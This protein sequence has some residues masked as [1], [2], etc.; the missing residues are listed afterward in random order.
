MPRKG[1]PSD[2]GRLAKRSTAITTG[3]MER[4]LRKFSISGAQFHAWAGCSF[5][6][7]IAMNPTWTLRRWQELVLEN[8]EAFQ[9]LN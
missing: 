1:L 8:L 6:E 4:F 3:A 9:P 7:W 2:V 5:K